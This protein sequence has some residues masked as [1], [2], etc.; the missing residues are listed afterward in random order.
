[1]GQ[2]NAARTNASCIDEPPFV[3]TAAHRPGLANQAH[4]VSDG[5]GNLGGVGHG[6]YFPILYWKDRHAETTKRARHHSGD[7]RRIP[8]RR[9][10]RSALRV[11]WR[12]PVDVDGATSV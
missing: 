10:S 1:M 6:A 4:E 12:L 3:H 5:G 7:V 11:N 8:A 2:S 9:W